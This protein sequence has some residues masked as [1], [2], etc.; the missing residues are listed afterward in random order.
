LGLGLE[1]LAGLDRVFER[2]VIGPR[3]FAA[4]E[5]NPRFRK[6]VASRFP[7]VIFFTERDNAVEVG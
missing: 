7:Y 1:F 6:A 5:P 4:W 2:I 3:Q